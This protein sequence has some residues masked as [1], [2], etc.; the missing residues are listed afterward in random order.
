M[1]KAIR[2]DD[3]EDGRN[4]RNASKWRKWD[5]QRECGEE[6]KRKIAIVH[7]EESKDG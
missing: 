5:G 2:G 1:I 4:G 6:G 3:A 7:D